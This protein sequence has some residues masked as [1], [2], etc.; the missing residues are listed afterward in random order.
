[1]KFFIFSLLFFSQIIVAQSKLTTIYFVRHA[2]K[3]DNSKDPDLSDFGKIRALKWKQIFSEIDLTAIYVTDFK[4][5]QQTASPTAESNNLKTL[6]YDFKSI[7][8]KQFLKDNATK[9]ILVI[10]HSNT[11]PEFVNSLI[12]SKTYE[13]I[14]DNEFGNLYIVT[15]VDGKIVHHQLLKIE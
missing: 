14:G 5:T 10:G 7:D 6:V 8:V 2:E 4:R 11:T 13:A 9:S 15:A 1:M 3:I 12:G